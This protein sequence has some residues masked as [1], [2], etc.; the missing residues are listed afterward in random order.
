MPGIANNRNG[1]GGLAHT[2]SISGTLSYYAGGGG[3][4]AHSD[5]ATVGGL[6]GG[7]G[8][9]DV[10]AGGATNGGVEG[11]NSASAVANTGG[12]SGGSGHGSNHLPGVGGSG[13]IVVRYP[14]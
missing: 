8:T 3:G 5:P 4:G 1:D 2:N 14:V 7:F 13:V 10:R 9:G 11:A 12:G 6:A